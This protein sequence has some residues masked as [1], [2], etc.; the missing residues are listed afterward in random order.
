V[1]NQGVS[2]TKKSSAL[3]Q[4]VT[5]TSPDGRYDQLFLSNYATINIIDAFKRIPGVGDA[6]LMTPA[7]YSMKVWL[8]SDRLT[9][10]GLTPNDI[11]R[12]DQAAEHA[13]CGRAHRRP[14]RPARPAVPAHHP[15]QGPALDVEEFESI[16]VRANPDG[17]FVRVRDVARVELAARLSESAR[18]ARWPSRGRDRP[19]SIARAATRSTAP[20]GHASCSSSSRPPF[21]Q[22]VEYRITYDTD[23]IREGKHQRA[24]S[25]R[26]SKASSWSSSWCSCSSGASGRP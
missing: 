8:D 26:C 5:I 4:I 20:S 25:T 11:A 17:S 24:W 19:L 12:R 1:R 16:V 10:F 15:D 21:P 23:R 2:V 6:S 14:A 18:A 3:L 9:S 13:G 22:G 7:D